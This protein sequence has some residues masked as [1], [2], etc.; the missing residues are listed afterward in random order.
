MH[1]EADAPRLIVAETEVA[2]LARADDFA[3]RRDGFLDRRLEI[4]GVE[5]PDIDVARVQALQ[6][7]VDFTH[8]PAAAEAAVVGLTAHPVVNLGGEYPA[9][10]LRA[11]H[12]AGD[13]F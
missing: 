3:D 2:D 11:D 4:V 8:Q 9:D 10:A 5:I 13:L 6:A 1:D 7:R 12:F